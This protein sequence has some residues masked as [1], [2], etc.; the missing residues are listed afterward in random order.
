M[1]RIDE[2]KGEI[3]SHGMTQADVAKA[4]GIHPVTFSKKLNKG[5]LN[6]NE[7]EA[8]IIVLSIENPS[9]IFF[10]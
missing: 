7:M 6:S 1:I 2:L 3:K 8:L 10:A 5:V 9:K 4:I